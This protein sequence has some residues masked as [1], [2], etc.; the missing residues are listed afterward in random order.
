[1]NPLHPSRRDW[2]RNTSRFLATAA[3]VRAGGGYAR[4]QDVSPRRTARSCIFINL[5]GAPSHVDTFDF[6]PGV[7]VPADARPS[8]SGKLVLNSTIFPSLS[9]R[10]ADLCVVRSVQSWEAAHERGQFYVQ[11]GHS[12]NPAFNSETPHL[13]AVIASELGAQSKLPPFLSLNG[14]PAQGATFLG[15]DFEALVPPLTAAGFPLLEH[16]YFG[17]RSAARFEEKFKLLDELDAEI[18][19]SGPHP[20]LT[21]H[22]AFYRTAKRLMYDPAVAEVFRFSGDD[23]A[24]YGGSNF[25]R[26][27]IVARNAVQ[28]D[29]GAVFVNINHDG[30]DTHQQMW[31]AGYSQNSRNMYGLCLELDQGLGAL[32]DDLKA[33]GKLSQTIIVAMGEFGRT[34]GPLNGR[35][36]RD[37]HKSA[38]FAV[39]AGGGI[40]GGRVIGATD[41]TG[42]R[43]ID[44][45]WSA[46]REV[47]MED[48]A[49]TIYSALGINWTRTI[50]DT[51]TGRA[52]SYIDF[53]RLSAQPIEEAFA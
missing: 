39:L 31:D 19:A 50:A 29:G 44:P 13:G 11:T 8:Q 32:L 51:P 43:I 45:G 22:A 28:A 53:G 41:A 24:R 35:G 36:G 14:S 26:A 40:A 34:P 9:T 30:W 6:K 47:Y 2:L 4:A 12:S 17:P 27:C 33:S 23:E 37:H 7:W 49:A 52:Y 15:G 16:N 25:G 5:I 1:M 46:A 10:G 42:N 21:R 48:I 3:L 18:R 20:V 38:Q